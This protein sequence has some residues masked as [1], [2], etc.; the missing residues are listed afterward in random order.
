M[1]LTYTGSRK[2]RL[3]KFLHE[4]MP[5]MSRSKIQKMIREQLVLVNKKPATVH[6]WLRKHDAI[7]IV[8]MEVQQIPPHPD[9]YQE[10]S[11]IY[12]DE[13][14][15]VL[16]KP[17]GMLMHPTERNEEHTLAHWLIKRFPHI[18][19]VGDD[20][21]RPGIVHRLDK[22][23]GGLVLVALTSTSF[24]FLKRLFFSHQVIKKYRCLVHGRMSHNEGQIQTPIERDKEGKMV[25]QTARTSGKEALTL[26]AVIKRFANYTLLDIQ[27]VTG[28]THQIRTHMYSIGHSIVGDSLYQTRDIRKKKK[29]PPLER[30]FLYAYHLSFAD[31][32]GQKHD[33]TVELPDDMSK[34]LQTLPS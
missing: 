15:A 13:A 11:I 18:A 12:Q 29:P 34:I 1:P 3:D 5:D 28:R 21:K 19:M 33:F 6:H 25:A 4:L 20:P 22:D 16:I 8:A 14:L 2:E 23:V 24:Q 32:D 31:Y 10:P 27:T 7:E 26:Y 17:A 9:S 30:P